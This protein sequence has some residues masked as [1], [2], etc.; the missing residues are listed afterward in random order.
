MAPKGPGASL[1]A[2]ARGRDEHIPQTRTPTPPSSKQHG[3]AHE[4]DTSQP[5]EELGP[6]PGGSGRAGAR[7]SHLCPGG[8][9]APSRLPASAPT[10]KAPRKFRRT[11]RWQMPGSLARGPGI[12]RTPPT[13]PVTRPAQR[14]SA[15]SS[16]PP[17]RRSPD[18]S[19]GPHQQHKKMGYPTPRRDSPQDFKAGLTFNNQ[20][21]CCAAL[22]EKRQ[23]PLVTPTAAEKAH[24]RG[25]D[26]FTV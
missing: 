19:A 10:P 3:G 15:L 13:H 17:E 22:T 1:A 26:L 23:P 21:A 9:R 4:A 14:W 24:G 6:C 12:P 16:A 2:Q 7:S 11:N 8:R 18:V 5:E 25:R 20:S